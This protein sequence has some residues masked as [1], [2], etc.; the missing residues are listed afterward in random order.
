MSDYSFNKQ[1][2]LLNA[3]HYQVV[4][5]NVHW[6]VS[7]KEF[8]LLCR[9]NELPHPRLGIVV[10]KKHVRLAVQR[11]RIKRLIRDS[12]RLNQHQL[13]GIDIIVLARKDAG[14]LSNTEILNQ[15][16]GLWRRLLKRC[17]N[18]QQ[19]PLAQ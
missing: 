2:R 13:A 15:T 7:T 4:F 19:K 6:K 5:N 10:A 8:L 11:N 1:L 12:F 18:D 16:T 17:Q 3:S 9:P 14:L